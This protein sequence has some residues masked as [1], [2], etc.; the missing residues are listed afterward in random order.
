PV[1]LRCEYQTAPLG[2]DCPQ[3]R[4]SWTLVSRHRHE[5]Q[6]A[7][8][9]LAASQA[10]LLSPGC[11]DLWDTGQVRSAASL[12][13]PYAGKPL[14]TA[15]R[16][17]WKV[18]VWD[19]A[20]D[21][22]AWSP[23]AHWQM[24]LLRARDWQASWISAAGSGND[25]TNPAPAAMLRKAFQLPG[26]ARRATLSVT[27]LGLY[28][29]HLNGRRVGDHLLAPEWTDYRTRVQSQTYDVTRWL[30]RGDNALGAILG[31][32]WYAGRLGMSDGILHRRRGV[33][34]TRP[35]LRLQLRI[36]LQDGR[37][38][39]VGSDASWRG[40]TDGPIRRS[41]LLDGEVYDARREM[42]GWDRP[43]FPAADWTPVSL[44]GGAE[45]RIVAQPNEPI[46][47]IAWLTPIAL[48]EPKPG[49]YLFDLGQN[50]VG[51]CRLRVRGQ[52]GVP[53]TLRYAEM[54][55]TDGTLYTANLRG[56]PQV[57]RYLPRGAGVE[58]FEPHFTYHG[59][60]FV[61]VSG[62]SRRPALHALTGVG[63]NSAAREVGQ[64]ECS[65]PRLNRLWRNI[66]WTERAN[67]MSV[68][69]DCPQRDERLGWMGDIQ[70][71][72]QTAMFNLD[73]AAFFT[74]WCQDIR[75]AQAD[76]GRFADFSP[77]PYGRNE[78]F[79]G[80]PA[81]GDAGVIV[82]WLAYVNYGDTRLLAR[83]FLAARRWVDYIHAR[84]PDLLW[85]RNRGNDYNDWLN[86]DWIRQRGW[87]TH[88]AAV[89]NEV[90]ATAFFAHSTE[91][92]AH[93]AAVLGRRPD[94]QH[95]QQLFEQICETFNRNFV[96]PD[97]GIQGDTQAGYALALDFD[98]LPAWLR[99]LA[100][101]RMVEAVH[102][103][104]EHLS[105]GI[106]TT[107]RLMLELTRNDCNALAWQLLTN[108]TFPSWGYMLDNGATT[109]WERWDGY[110]RGR[111][112]QDPGMNSFNHWA[113]GAVGE[114]LWR[115]I[116]GINPDPAHPAY[117]RC[118]IRPQPGGGV[119]W[120]RAR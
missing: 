49:V 118:A 58:R 63:F 86:G 27:A 103:Y 48:T 54:T 30:R 71:F 26:R 41:D 65:D 82:P 115:N 4:L 40:T 38:L 18:C 79:T 1:E 98:L 112:F 24:G 77:H 20:G 66:L 9:I 89:P 74:K 55:N 31:D 67:L 53:V 90:F 106:Q 34:G 47:Q 84:N 107:H 60:R 93:M 39:T 16:V 88:G 59:F 44:E 70:A 28:E 8:R 120:A 69:T 33:Y 114:W 83:Q 50:M 81:W 51:W 7:Y 64:F 3:P 104:H 6:T 78:R 62:L 21:G 36:E 87:P 5:V 73:L 109:I 52:R 29:I 101:R 111:G 102:R 57:D 94:A 96:G 80:T 97:G 100:A 117:E 105:T 110:V 119:T 13:I 61:E 46:R 76:D 10:R 45:P 75:D 72:S 43:G 56:A 22:S 15:M 99:P 108:R 85:R 32:G 95:Y 14:A 68:P 25:G 92:V 11:A 113:F 17:Y 91:L 12:Q 116:A 42:P 37:T 2:I 19:G 23:I 35:L